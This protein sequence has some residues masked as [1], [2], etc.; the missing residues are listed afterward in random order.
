MIASQPEGGKK[1]NNRQE[2]IEMT[3][4]RA[5]LL[6]HYTSPQ[7]ALIAKVPSFQEIHYFPI[8]LMS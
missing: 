2:C 7:T 5:L 1:G 8:F 6:L 4:E 3:T